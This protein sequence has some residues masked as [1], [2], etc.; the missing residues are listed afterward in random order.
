MTNKPVLAQCCLCYTTLQ[1][2]S[3]SVTVS[4]SRGEVLYGTHFF[5]ILLVQIL[6]L[7]CKLVLY[8]LNVQFVI[9][10]SKYLAYLE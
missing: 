1:S 3:L 4:W 6:G 2:L 7:I 10:L 9:K 5:F 8:V